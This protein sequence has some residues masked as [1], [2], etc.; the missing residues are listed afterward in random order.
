M[1]QWTLQKRWIF[2]VSVVFHAML[3]MAA[4]VLQSM[5]LPHLKFSGLVPLLLPIVSTGAA[6]YQG[7]VA[8]GVVGLFAGIFCD[9]SFNAPAGGFTVL[10]TFTGLFV[11]FLADTVMAR[12]FVTYII[13]CAVVLAISAFAQ[14]FPLLLFE[15]IPSKPLLMMAVRQ[16]V[17]SL[18]YSLPI[19]FFVRALGKRAQRVSPSGRPL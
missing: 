1:K 10:L 19:W 7:R 13:S 11:G 2:L 15:R 17:Y 3:L 6:V 5:I 12:G 9:I 8:G 18:I 16:T 14:M 4:Y